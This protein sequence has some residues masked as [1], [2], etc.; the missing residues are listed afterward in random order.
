MGI[1]EVRRIS[2]PE[3]TCQ[4]QASQSRARV[5]HL[6]RQHV[7]AN[8]GLTVA[9]LLAQKLDVTDM[10]D[11]HL[12]INGEAGANGGAKY[13]KPLVSGGLWGRHV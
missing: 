2:R 13:G 5:G 12:R 3:G 4:V 11:A 7:T 9:A 1:V 10:V 6:R 8:G